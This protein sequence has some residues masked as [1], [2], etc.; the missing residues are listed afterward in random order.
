MSRH[1]I[2][3]IHGMGQHAEGWSQPA[4]R[5]LAEAFKQALPGRGELEE[6]FDLRELQYSDLFDSYWEQFDGNAETL[7]QIPLISGA[8]SLAGEITAYAARQPDNSFL[9]THVGDILLYASSHYNQLVPLALNLQM[10]EVFQEV[11]HSSYSIIAHSL[12]TRVAHDLLQR[13]FTGEGAYQLAAKPK[14][15]INCANV[16]RLMSFDDGEFGDGMV[17]YPSDS[18]TAGACTYYINASHKL[19]PVAMVRRYEPKFRADP[20]YR[21][22][23]LEESDVTDINVHDLGHYLRH[24]LVHTAIFNLTMADYV[25]QP[26][27]VTEAKVAELLAAY[28]QGTTYQQLKSRLA[29]IKQAGWTEEGSLRDV[30]DHLAK[31][32]ALIR[33]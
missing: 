9:R 33:S 13:T 3:L 22:V 10:L 4:T 20:L 1:V 19:D 14:L 5:V 32:F 15:F 30:V 29:Q 6:Y 21:A 7:R 12:G 8:A 31:F 28:R 24:P 25:G 17:V 16:T 2:F 11:G 23:F 27:R 26:A 18:G